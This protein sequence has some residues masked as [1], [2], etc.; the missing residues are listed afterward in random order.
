MIPKIIHQTWKDENIPERWKEAVD[1]CISLH[2]KYKYILWTDKMM[3]KFVKKFYPEFYAT[4]RSY[5]YDIQR[6]DA[7][8]Y[9][10]LYK[11]G[12]IYLDMDMMCKKKLDDL[13]HYDLVV[14]H[15]DHVRRY[16]RNAFY[17][18]IPKHPFFRYCIEELPN[19]KND[20]SCFGGHWNI[21]NSTG[22]FFLTNRLKEYG[23]IPNMHIMKKYEYE[24]DCNNCNAVEDTCEGGKYFKPIVG[25]S[26][27]KLDTQMYN[28]GECN[29]PEMIAGLLVATLIGSEYY[30]FS[31]KKLTSEEDTL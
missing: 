18:S 31:S 4:Y 21:M 14:V 10:V 23:K 5:P 22:P 30:Y 26:W 1:S 24:G 25:R 28:F 8:R 11:Y 17:M 20:Y 16:W 27:N 29:Y 19:H 7:F 3:S 15:S 6:C 2:P 13:L 12:G 9:L